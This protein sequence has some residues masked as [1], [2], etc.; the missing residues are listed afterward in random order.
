MGVAEKTNRIDPGKKVDPRTAWRIR[1]EEKE[2]KWEQEIFIKFG[3]RGE[4]TLV[5][6]AGLLRGGEWK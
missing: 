3:R 4:T 6:G 5:W 2:K 1:K